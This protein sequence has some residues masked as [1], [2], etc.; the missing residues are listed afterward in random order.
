MFKNLSIG[1]KGTISSLAI[2]IAGTLS[3]VIGIYAAI[4]MSD[5]T[6]HIEKIDNQ[7][8]HN[9]KIISGH[10]KFMGDMCRAFAN[11]QEF[12]G[13]TD[14]NDCILGKWYYPAKAAGEFNNL[15]SEMKEKFAKMEEEHAKIHNIAKEYK[16]SYIHLDRE[17]KDLIYQKEIDH[18]NWAKSLSNALVKN[19]IAKVQIDSHLCGFGKW[20]DS[21]IVSDEFKTLDPKIKTLLS[22]IK[23][24]HDKL[25]NSAKK[26]ISLQKAKKHSKAMK[27]YQK[28]TL[29]YLHK[30]QIIFHDILERIDSIDKLNA[31]I[32]HDIL[33]SAPKYFK[34]VLLALEHYNEVLEIKHSDLI[35]NNESLLNTIYMLFTIMA[36]MGIIAFVMG[37]FINKGIVSSVKDVESGLDNFFKFLRRELTDVEKIKITSEDELG[38]MAKVI[39]EN[40]ETLAIGFT[41]DNQVI[42]EVA[43]VVEKAKAGLYSYDVKAQASNPELEELR[44]NMNDMINITNTN[45]GLI[46]ETL[47]QFGNANFTSTVKIQ[48]SGNIGSL[49]KGTNALGGSISEILSMIANTADQ[50]NI[51]ADALASVSEELSTAANEQASSLEETAASIEEITSAI[52]S[53][54]DK[55][56]QMNEITSE[57]KMTSSRGNQLATQTATAMDEIN[58]ATSDIEQAITIIDQIAFQTNIL[59]LNAAV[60]A[61][62]AGEAGKGFAVVAGEV[63][64]LAAR[65][66]EAA[67]E[68]KAI[69][70]KA[71]NRAE[72]GKTIA[73]EMMTGYADLNSKVEITS[74]LVQDVENA[75]KEQMSGM[76]QINTAIT[77][78]DQAT[79]ENAAASH[80]VSTKAGE[81]HTVT[82]RLLSVVNRTTFDQS[83]RNSVCDVNLTFDTTKLKLDHIA[84]KETNFKKIG[85]GNT[86]KVATEKECDLGKWIDAHRNESYTSSQAWNELL[87]VHEHVHS[88]VQDYIDIDGKNKTD[89]KL[90]DIAKDIENDTL[91]V[92]ELIDQ[93]KIIKCKDIKSNN[94]EVLI[95]NKVKPRVLNKVSK[96]N[97]TQAKSSMVTDEWD[98]F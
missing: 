31:P 60:E 86:W 85:D 51:S 50:L 26:I 15:S 82:D 97:I 92:F 42:E 23:I 87:R 69:V 14:H 28:E 21:F 55:A 25:H 89:Q 80:D 71:S 72:E 48:A 67:N 13:G 11:N 9:E 33:V 73:D 96:P 56:H 6:H 44:L 76:D 75:S 65:S 1:A 93:L 64:N 20:Y 19:K 32:K 74:S 29:V 63:R 54:A 30:V 35:E 98:S 47:I 88:G 16:E 37:W 4:S 8:L 62:T 2:A 45:L 95:E 49:T 53:T 40:V 70:L 68:I 46:T 58:T 57:L 18:L 3:V 94:S 52:R 10:E 36:L 38:Q 59:S 91:S 41:Q 43:V 83:K 39:N 84:F 7:I 81:L 27:V 12:H 22:S 34:D 66:A 24:P 61:A 77:Q 79:Q 5:S 17:L 78:L 90:M